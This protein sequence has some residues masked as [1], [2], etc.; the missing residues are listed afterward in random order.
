MEQEPLEVHNN[1]EILATHDMFSCV[2]SP[3][4]TGS[5]NSYLFPCPYLRVLE[6][7]ECRG[8]GACSGFV[9]GKGRGSDRDL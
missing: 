4:S 3:H 1:M 9:A 2:E 6:V 8:G 7:R 5:G